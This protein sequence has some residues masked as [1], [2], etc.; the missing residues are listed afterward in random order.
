MGATTSEEDRKVY[1][2]ELAELVDR[3]VN[4]IRGW[5]RSGRLPEHLHSTRNPPGVGMG[6]RY[7]TSEQVVA[8]SQ[9]MIDEKIY[10]GAGLKNFYPDAVYV[11]ESL[12]RLRM[13]RTKEAAA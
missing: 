7:W 11:E 1:I 13:G 12:K 2:G 3:R 10:P 6:W 8:I 9:W 5:E 4:T